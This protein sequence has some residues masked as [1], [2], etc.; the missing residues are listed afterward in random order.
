MGRIFKPWY[1]IRGP[2]GERIKKQSKHYHCEWTDTFG[3]T[4]HK[5][6][7]LTERAARDVLRKIEG[8]V[9]AER[10]GLPTRRLADIPVKELMDS[11]LTSLRA[12]ATKK[13]SARRTNQ[14]SEIVAE[15]RSVY[16]RD[17]TPERVETYLAGLDD[18]GLGAR[19]INTYAQAIKGMFAWAVRQRKLPYNP[20]DGIQRPG[21]ASGSC[22]APGFRGSRCARQSPACPSRSHTRER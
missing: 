16:I 9:L 18:V 15:T 20:L 8:D 3:K 13:H 1:Y 21:R 22:L 17:L 4:R 5:K 10:N 6:A 19:T 14:L 2:D 7:A 12:G 11:Y